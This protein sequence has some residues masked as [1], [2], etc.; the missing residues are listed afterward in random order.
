MKGKFLLVL[1]TLLISASVF[2]ATVDTVSIYSNSMHKY[3]KCVVIAPK[4]YDAGGEKFPVLYLLHGYSGNYGDW[5][6]EI[7]FRFS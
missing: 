3:V 1:C 7:A 6:R 5:I 2:A 4:G